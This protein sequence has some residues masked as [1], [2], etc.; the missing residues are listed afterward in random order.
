MRVHGTY[1]NGAM[2]SKASHIVNDIPL[3]A[4]PGKNDVAFVERRLKEIKAEAKRLRDQTWRGQR[5]HAR[6][7]HD[8]FV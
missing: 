3:C 5:A 2:E 4:G 1:S 6:L 8:A 7:L